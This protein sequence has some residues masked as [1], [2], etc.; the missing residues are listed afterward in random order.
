MDKHKPFLTK[1]NPL[2][3]DYD[4][5]ESFKLRYLLPTYWL[6]W[7]GIS[8]SS[9]LVFT[10]Q[11]LRIVIGKLIGLCIYTFNKKRADIARTNIKM[12]FP[13]MDNRSIEKMTS[14]YFSNLGRTFT[15]FPILWWKKD[16][17]IQKIIE[18][19]QKVLSN[20]L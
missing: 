13:N 19:Q 11:T 9:L 2:N 4:E 10:P 8:F 6:T 15:D 20:G 3:I 5:S 17:A 7:I 16:E 14:R 12:C 18:V 1:R